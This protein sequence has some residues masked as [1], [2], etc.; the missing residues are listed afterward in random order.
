MSYM[1]HFANFDHAFLASEW[2][3]A[4]SQFHR[5]SF[6]PTSTAASDTGMGLSAFDE[7]VS[8]CIDDLFKFTSISTQ[9][10][11]RE[12]QIPANTHYKVSEPRTHRGA[13]LIQKQR[14]LRW[15]WADNVSRWWSQAIYL[16]E[17]C[18]LKSQQVFTV[19]A[20]LYNEILNWGIRKK[21][22]RENVWH[23]L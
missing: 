18:L 19:C 20:Y 4:L 5:H 13:W 10:D 23:N 17:A 14:L 9:R 16:Q 12:R 15:V 22:S 21:N 6:C 7:C 2:E 8:V 1:N 11:S 3:M